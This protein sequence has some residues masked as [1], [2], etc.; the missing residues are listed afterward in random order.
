MSWFAV[1]LNVPRLGTGLEHRRSAPK[2]GDQADLFKPPTRP[3][4]SSLSS[5][6]TSATS[7]AIEVDNRRVSHKSE[8]KL[9]DLGDPD[10]SHQ[11]S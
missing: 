6:T 8:L 3:T 5:L 9:A 7:S 1:E 4:L 2:L 10:T 11:Q